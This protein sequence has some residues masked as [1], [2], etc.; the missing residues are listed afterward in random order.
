MC[1]QE[2]ENGDI[3]LSITIVYALNRV[4]ELHVWNTF[5]DGQHFN[6]FH[7]ASESLES[8]LWQ[9]IFEMAIKPVH[10]F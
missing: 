3:M 2:E 7:E 1:L 9:D 6:A 8:Y 10:A 4:S 5:M